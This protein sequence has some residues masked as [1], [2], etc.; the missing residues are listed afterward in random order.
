M[1]RFKQTAARNRLSACGAGVEAHTAMP[2][3]YS[4]AGLTSTKDACGS[5]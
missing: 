3:G 2:A 5:R 4:L 1:A